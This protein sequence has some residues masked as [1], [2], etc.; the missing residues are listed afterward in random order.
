MVERVQPALLRPRHA[1]LDAVHGRLD[2]PQGGARPA[3][4]ISLCQ[5][6]R[7]A[8]SEVAGRPPESRQKRKSVSH[9]TQ[10]AWKAASDAERL[11]IG[12]RAAARRRLGRFVHAAPAMERDAGLPLG[13][14]CKGMQSSLGGR[15]PRR[16]A[17]AEPRP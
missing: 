14:C 15:L 1:F 11:P 6:C 5:P 7:N 12:T 17:A 2:A 4:G 8:R 16:G 10:C 9:L 13:D 3:R